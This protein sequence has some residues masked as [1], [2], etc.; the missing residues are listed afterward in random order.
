MLKDN[1]KTNNLLCFYYG[2]VLSLFDPDRFVIT[3]AERVLCMK[4]VKKKNFHCQPLLNLV[5]M[6]YKTVTIWL[7]QIVYSHI[8]VK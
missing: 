6:F 8:P 7:G 1:Q 5:Y 2:K 3:S 4:I